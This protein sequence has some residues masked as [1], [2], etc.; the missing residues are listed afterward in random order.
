MS[1]RIVNYTKYVTRGW[2]QWRRRSGIS[3]RRAKLCSLM[4]FIGRI[5]KKGE[6]KSI[7]RSRLNLC[8]VNLNCLWSDKIL[9]GI[10][11]LFI[12][13]T[14]FHLWPLPFSFCLQ[15]FA[16]QRTWWRRKSDLDQTLSN[17]ENR[18]NCRFCV[19]ATETN[20]STIIIIDS[21]PLSRRVASG[22]SSV[23]WNSIN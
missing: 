8:D 22:V 16:V 3:R 18:V 19:A 20:R 6:N 13:I 15:V 17:N 11:L 7:I 9:V 21:P 4:T 10:P 12:I 5:P 14:S 2:R 23:A 1:W